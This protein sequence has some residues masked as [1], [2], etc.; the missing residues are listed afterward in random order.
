LLDRRSEDALVI[1]Q[2]GCAALAEAGVAL[3]ARELIA[4]LGLE[5]QPAK[6]IAITLPSGALL[7][8]SL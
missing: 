4:Q 8:G 7:D 6:P 5:Q 3:L 2:G 1:P